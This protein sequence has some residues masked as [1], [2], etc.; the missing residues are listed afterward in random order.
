MT[1]LAI[2]NPKGG[3]GKT[4][5]ATNL[6]RALHERKY[7]VLIVDSDP[8]GSAR[9]WHAANETNPIP[10]VALDRANNLSTIRTMAGSY[11]HIIIDGAAKLENM[12][13]GAIK[14]SDLVLIPV[15]PSPYDVW[16]T[17]DLVDVIKAR[18]EVTDGK[19]RAAFVVMRKIDRT[20]L[21]ADVHA[22]LAEYGLP[23]LAAEIVQRQ[24][25]PRTAAAG[26][27]VIDGNDPKAQAEVE[28][29]TTEVLALLEQGNKEARDGTYGQ[30]AQQV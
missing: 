4:T 22:A 8:Q 30:T 2:L 17:S 9:D 15:Q 25:Y 28:E 7:S 3:C 24:V 6:A 27:T 23:V 14:V 18:Q 29:L 5:L 20:R 16:A 19:P 12:L 1:I 10:L 11:D 21:G 13:A 26:L